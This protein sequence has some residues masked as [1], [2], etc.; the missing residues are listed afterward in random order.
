MPEAV[1]FKPNVFKRYAYCCLT[2]KND[3]IQMVQEKKLPN[4]D[5][6]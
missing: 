1:L 3:P 4:F 5:R 6:K 2:V